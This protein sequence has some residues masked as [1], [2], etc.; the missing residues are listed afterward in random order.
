MT[1]EDLCMELQRRAPGAWELYRKTA[2]SRDLEARRQLRRLA[3]HREEGWAARWWEGGGPRFAAASSP[4][5]L[6]RAIAEA[7][8]IG[9]ATEPP[10]EWPSGQTTLPALAPVEPPPDLF[11]ELSRA[12]SSASRG[13]ALLSSLSLRSGSVRE[14]IVNGAGLDVAQVQPLLDGIAVALARGGPRAHEARMP[15]RWPGKPEIESLAQRLADAGTLPLSD[16]PTP[17]SAGQWLLDPAVSAALLA[18]V[19]PLF[20]AARTPRWVGRGPLAAP[21]VSIADDASADAPFDGEGVATR[22]I[23]LVEAG[24]RVGH[25]DD[26]RSARRSGRHPTGHGVRPSFRTPP[27]AGPRRISLETREPVARAA[28]LAGV[29]RG[30]FA[31]A[32]TAPVRVDLAEDRYEIEFTGISV[33]AGRAQGPVAGARAAG[34]I[35]ELLR[36]I[37]GMSED[38]QF[39][40]MPFLTGSPTLLVERASFD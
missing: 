25:L 4:E 17:F 21:G 30:L 22:R 36:R 14:R 35:S 39:F 28:L 24:A 7:A 13:D 40:P 18:A 27:R 29:T 2:Q 1:F 38:R 11:D 19:S 37:T 10:P 32:L 12:I 33:I 23:L 16:R 26:L 31:A 3:W 15:F 9:T 6:S 5:D 20:S 34:R 8:R